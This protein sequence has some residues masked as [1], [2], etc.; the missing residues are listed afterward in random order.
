MSV[1]QTP[2]KDSSTESGTEYFDEEAPLDQEI[3][4]PEVVDPASCSEGRE[5][6]PTA[7]AGTD[8]RTEKTQLCDQN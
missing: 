5:W 6:L 3:V 7:N 2:D 1:T 4:D 8:N